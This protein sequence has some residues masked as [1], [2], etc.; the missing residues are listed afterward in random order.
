MSALS[1]FSSQPF[2][3][4]AIDRAVSQPS[5]AGKSEESL[6]QFADEVYACAKLAGRR[7]HIGINTYEGA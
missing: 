2:G 6:G 1:G 4:K 3:R 7:I 5:C